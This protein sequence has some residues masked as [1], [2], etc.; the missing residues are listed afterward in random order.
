MGVVG[1]NAFRKGLKLIINDELWEVVD[2]EYSKMARRGAVVRTKLRNI[3]TGAAQDRTF[4]SGVTFDTPDIEIRTMQYRYS[5]DIAYNFMDTESYEQVPISRNLLGEA[6]KY[7][8]EQQEVKVQIYDGNPIG[9]E[10]PTVVE[11]EVTE[12]EPG[13]KGDTVSSTTKPATL[14]TGAIVNVPLFVDTGTVIRIDT[15]TGKYLERA[16]TK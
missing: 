11:L 15:R 7:L 5:D 13:V 8:K 14:E 2:Y 9:V 3:V 4:P 1:T 10:L 12:T 16:K 6:Q